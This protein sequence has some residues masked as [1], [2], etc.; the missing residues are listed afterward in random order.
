MELQI[1]SYKNLVTGEK[2]MEYRLGKLEDI[3]S[4]CRLVKAA[5]ETM[6]SRG[7]HQWDELYPTKED[8][9]ADIQNENLYVV[10]ENNTIVAIYVISREY[11]SEYIKG[12]WECSSETACVIHRLCVSPAVQNKG[13]GKEILIHIENQ[14]MDKG[15]E[16]VRLD[17]FSENPYAIRLYENNGYVKRGHTDWRKG[18][19]WLMEKK[20]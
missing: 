9:I 1:L 3:D 18:R 8:F 17:V 11:D 15:F 7:I 2:Y 12:K 14:L 4:I 19:F 13:V 5:I 20:L 10:F 6:E 16:S